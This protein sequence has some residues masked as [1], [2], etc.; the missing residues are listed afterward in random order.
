MT[1]YYRGLPFKSS[2]HVVFISLCAAFWATFDPNASCIAASR[3]VVIIFSML[4]VGLLLLL[5]CC[6]GCWW[7]DI[8]FDLHLLTP[9]RALIIQTPD[10]FCDG[11]GNR[12]A[13]YSYLSSQLQS[14]PKKVAPWSF[15]HLLLMTKCT[16]GLISTWFP[17][18]WSCKWS[19]FPSAKVVAWVREAGR[20]TTAA[21][22][23]GRSRSSSC[24]WWCS[25]RSSCCSCHH[26]FPSSSICW[27]PHLS[28]FASAA[29]VRFFCVRCDLRFIR[30][31][32]FFIY[33]CSFSFVIFRSCLSSS[34]PC[35][36]L[37][38]DHHW[39]HAPA[40]QSSKIIIPLSPTSSSFSS[41]SS[42]SS[43]GFVCPECHRL[44]DPGTRVCSACGMQFTQ[45]HD[46]SKTQWFA[47]AFFSP[48]RA[49]E[50]PSRSYSQVLM[51]SDC[52]WHWR[53]F[54]SISSAKGNE[55]VAFQEP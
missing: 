45:A 9:S 6:T 29:Q 11:C 26:F 34:W 13:I 27:C 43:S 3:D 50:H 24:G 5:G 1:W 42:S 21:A 39:E 8:R 38:R 53:H 40:Q 44:V 22:T 23:A 31:L 17:L 49:S 25:G 36:F 30:Y 4:G 32:V 48:H 41:S 7:S 10:C 20:A 19:E 35:G 16:D 46:E 55:T 12:P 54:F 28:S 15:I 52:C 47:T 33:F 14:I 2:S 51:T 18:H 37:C